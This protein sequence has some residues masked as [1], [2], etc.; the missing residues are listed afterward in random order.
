[1]NGENGADPTEAEFAETESYSS[2]SSEAGKR[3]RESDESGSESEDSMSF[4]PG[5]RPKRARADY[6]KVIATSSQRIT[7]YGDDI[8]SLLRKIT[9]EADETRQGKLNVQVAEFKVLKAEQ[10]V[11]KAEAERDRTKSEVEEL[12][13]KLTKAT[14][15]NKE[16]QEKLLEQKKL[17]I[18]ELEKRVKQA[19]DQHR[20]EQARLNELR[21]PSSAAAAASASALCPRFADHPLMSPLPPPDQPATSSKLKHR[22]LGRRRPGPAA[23]PV[24]PVG[25]DSSRPP[26]AGQDRTTHH[27]N[28]EPREAPGNL[29]VSLSQGHGRDCPHAE[30]AS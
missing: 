24:A 22:H 15:K 9:A 5:V 7:K 12:E 17:E 26:G 16:S 2:G 21:S 30:R 13:R 19:Q 28:K 4:L 23:Y 11:L 10:E 18:E 6:D 29:R 27:H 3:K 8:A 14:K 20:V 1:M 25:R